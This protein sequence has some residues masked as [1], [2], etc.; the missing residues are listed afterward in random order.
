MTHAPRW[1]VG[2]VEGRQGRQQD[3]LIARGADDVMQYLAFVMELHGRMM[4]LGESVVCRRRSRSLGWKYSM[5]MLFDAIGLSGKGIRRKNG[6]QCFG[7]V[8]EA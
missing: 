1:Y 8:A 4:M 2:S 3:V 5:V 7:S 6:K